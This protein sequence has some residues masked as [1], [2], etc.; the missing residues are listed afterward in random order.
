[1]EALGIG[2]SRCVSRALLR[3]HVHHDRAIHSEHQPQHLAQ[4]TDVVPVDGRRAHNTKLLVDHRFGQEHVLHGILGALTELRKGATEPAARFQPILHAL[5]HTAIAV[6]SA[7]VAEMLHERAHVAR[8]GHLVV[9]QDDDH[10]Q[11]F[12]ADVVQRFERHAARHR[13]IADD[14]DDLLVG[15]VHDTRLGVAGGHRQRIGGMAGRMRIVGALARTREAGEA[16]VG[17]QGVELLQAARHQLVRIG[18]M[19]HIEDEL[20]GGRIQQAVACQD[21][22]HRAQRRGHMT[23]GLRRGGD[24]LLADLIGQD[25]QLRHREQMEVGRRGDAIQ[26]AMLSQVRS[27][28]AA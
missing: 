14:G 10:G 8:D 21:D 20:V 2:H 25:G 17:A 18:L 13:R 23:A 26:Y 9:V 4:L 22:L 7:Q 16:M 28:G 11:L 1:M 5:A 24:D 15:A 12:G 27:L 19:P 3:H 6:G